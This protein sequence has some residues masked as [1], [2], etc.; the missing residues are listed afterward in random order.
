M[1]ALP[2]I[3]L[4]TPSFNQASFHW[5]RRFDRCWNTSSCRRHAEDGFTLG[6]PAQKSR[7]LYH[8]LLQQRNALAASGLLPYP[9]LMARL[10]G[11]VTR[12]QGQIPLKMKLKAILKG[13]FA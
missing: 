3:S 13:L 2:R 8:D 10:S 4:V 5:K 11:E 6:R 9:D 12:F 7:V 1:N